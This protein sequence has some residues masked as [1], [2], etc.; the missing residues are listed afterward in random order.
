M[1]LGNLLLIEHA[2]SVT[3]HHQVRHDPDI[4]FLKKEYTVTVEPLNIIDP[5]HHRLDRQLAYY[6]TLLFDLN[7]GCGNIYIIM[8]KH[9]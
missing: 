9:A 5:G 7:I 8:Q 3:A 4:F 1:K 6:L 2:V